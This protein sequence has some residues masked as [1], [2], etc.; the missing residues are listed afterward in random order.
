MKLF[1]FENFQLTITEEALLIKAFRDLWERDESKNKEQ[2]FLEMGFVYFVYDPRSDFMFIVNE[3]DRIPKVKEEVGIPE[4]WEPDA[5]ILR[6]IET[7]KLLITTV[8]TSAIDSSRKLIDKLK[9]Y[10]DTID[11]N[12]KDSK[13]APVH[14]LSNITAT[15]KQIPA[16]TIDLQKAEKVLN[17]EIEENAK[18]R[19]AGVKK[20]LEDGFEKIE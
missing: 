6:A 13:G 3:E 15:I 4:D 16:L 9:V 10:L 17:S 12:E 19:G 8:S 18:M 1:K 14:S 11:L 2:F 5:K 20:I 7:Y